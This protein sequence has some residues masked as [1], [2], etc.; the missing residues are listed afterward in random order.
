MVGLSD[1]HIIS[2]ASTTQNAFGVITI[3]AVRVAMDLGRRCKRNQLAD[4]L[5][6]GT[7]TEFYT[8]NPDVY[9][10]LYEIVQMRSK[11]S[12]SLRTVEFG[13]ANKAHSQNSVFLR[14]LNGETQRIN[15]YDWYKNCLGD[16]KKVHFDPFRRT[17]KIMFC[18]P[19]RDGQP[20]ETTI[21]QLVF[22]RKVF[23]SGIMERLCVKESRRAMEREMAHCLAK[24]RKRG[25]A[26]R[27]R[28][29]H[30]QSRF[31]QNV[32]PAEAIRL[33]WTVK[34]PR[35]RLKA[36]MTMKQSTCD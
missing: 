35:K 36:T 26:K 34:R 31:Q 13:V 27:R 28:H 15:V 24:Q 19:G 16:Y 3:Y 22:S 7:L 25:A 6:L 29:E 9:D 14:K 10:K 23:S 17:N 8:Q 4:E 12:P 21:A 1:T 11:E 30:K 2:C 18:I 32:R 20:I 5:L 33:T